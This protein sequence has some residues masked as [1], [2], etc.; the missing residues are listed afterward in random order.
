MPSLLAVKPPPITVVTTTYKRQLLLQETV[1]SVQAQTFQD[2][3]YLVVDDA[4]ND[5]TWD[6][7]ESAARNDR[8][9]RPMRM[10]RNL[11]RPGARNHA[12]E[13][14]AGGQILFL[15]DDDLLPPDALAFHK[16]ALEENPQAA[17]SV[18]GHTYFIEQ[19]EW[20]SPRN[21]SRGMVVKAWRG[22]L[23]GWAAVP[24]QM[25]IRTQAIRRVGGWDE[26]FPEFAEDFATYFALFRGQEVVLLPE[27]TLRYRRHAGQ[28]RPADAR[29][30]IFDILAREI[31]GLQGKERRLAMRLV[32]A[33]R[34]LLG[35][36]ENW[37]GRRYPAAF[38][39]GI[40]LLGA[41]PLLLSDPLTRHRLF[42]PLRQRRIR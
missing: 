33:R 10:Q 17:A 12:L 26:G 5:G 9:I 7:L 13:R 29:R 16:T 35:A 42:R 20:P 36:K 1:A 31:A 28:S 23:F 39:H 15:D 19:G 24:G 37:A 34:D 8:R 6:W 25:M 21:V 22:L 40:R 14:A 4:S 38:G 2:F 18:G 11:K 3:E 27:I 32:G 41:L 30:I